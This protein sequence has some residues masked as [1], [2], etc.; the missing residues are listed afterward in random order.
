MAM[1]TL[2]VL[3]LAAA[4]A[5]SVSAC[6]RP[7]GSAPAGSEVGA[8]MPDTSTPRDANPRM[9]APDAG[10]T[11]TVPADGS[12]PAVAPTPPVGTAGGSPGVPGATETPQPVP[13]KQ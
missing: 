4:A 13:G 9:T 1:R 6:K 8:A 12:T 2:L 7:T 11:G 3:S 10:A 5:L